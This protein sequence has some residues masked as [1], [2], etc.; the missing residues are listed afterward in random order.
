MDLTQLLIN[1]VRIRNPQAFR[2]YET[3]KN[4]GGNP[5][6]FLNQIMGNYTPEQ[7]TQFTQFAKQF[8]ISTEQLSKYGIGN[9]P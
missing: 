9:K 1:Q 8:G 2:K 3:L 7:I 4:N 5:Q 6:E